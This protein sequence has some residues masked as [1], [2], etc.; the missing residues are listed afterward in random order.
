MKNTLLIHM[1]NP[2]TG[3]TALQSFLYE[4]KKN[5]EEYGWLYPDLRDELP[6]TFEYIV[7]EKNGDVFF[8]RLI[9][10]ERRF[11]ISDEN[12]KRVWKKILEALADK[13]VILSAEGLSKQSVAGEFLEKAKSEYDNIKVVIYLR[14][15]DRT[16]ESLWNQKIRGRGK[17]KYEKSFD[18]FIKE[19]QFIQFLHYKERLDNISKIIGRE[20]VIVRIYEKQQFFEK[21]HTI[22]A[23]FLSVIGIAPDWEKWK[24][25]RMQNPR[26]DGNYI[27]IMRVFN[28]LLQIEEIDFEQYERTLIK[29]SQ[30]FSEKK[31]DMGYFTPEERREFLAQ[32]VSENEYIAR[33]YMGRKNGV[34]FYDVEMDYPMD[35]IHS[36]TVFEEDIIRTFL[37]MINKE[38]SKHKKLYSELMKVKRQNDFLAEQILIQ[39]IGNRK[40]LFFGA[41]KKGAELLKRTSLPVA[42]MVDNDTEKEG[43]IC[44]GGGVKGYVLPRLK[45]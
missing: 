24:D 22:A 33:E 38:S 18:D 7:R 36:C 28:S 19:N 34:L 11:N 44:G 3:T 2:K 6:E 32:F 26:L 37:S 39:R 20:N 9:D 1:G 35:D 17:W 13:N 42:W 12:W 31:K 45:V 41:G 10:G 21:Q 30:I 4:N 23:D 29:L 43:K 5:L 40:L 27:E 14:R 8:G 15:Q 16:I 25:C